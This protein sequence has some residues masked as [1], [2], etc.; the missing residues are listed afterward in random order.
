MSENSNR[1]KAYDY[2]FGS[3][4][5]SGFTKT[6]GSSLSVSEANE[7]KKE[8]GGGIEEVLIAMGA[9]LTMLCGIGC[10]TY[11]TVTEETLR[12]LRRD[13]KI[14]KEVIL[15]LAVKGYDAYTPCKGQLPI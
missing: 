10:V 14:P 4:S 7:S 1:K 3:S 13:Y 11:S 2:P 9:M 6:V 12:R 5:R 8:V 15:S